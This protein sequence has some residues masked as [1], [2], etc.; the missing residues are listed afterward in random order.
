MRRN[1]E[2]PGS[3]VRSNLA[4][5]HGAAGPDSSDGS[6]AAP[7]TAGAA[8]VAPSTGGGVVWVDVEPPVMVVD[9]AA[10]AGPASCRTMADTAPIAIRALPPITAA[11]TFHVVS[12]GG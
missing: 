2:N 10:L 8:T 7:L 11:S 1:C 6:G 12:G 4:R 9:L 5:T 3:G